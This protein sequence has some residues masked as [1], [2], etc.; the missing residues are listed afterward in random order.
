M[1]TQPSAAYQRALFGAAAALIGVLALYAGLVVS[2][3]G[4]TVWHGLA[5]TELF[6]QGSTAALL[7]ATPCFWAS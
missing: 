3:I 2:I 4:L 5:H 7:Y 6:A 1:N